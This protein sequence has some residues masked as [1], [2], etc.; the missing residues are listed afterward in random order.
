MMEWVQIISY[1]LTNELHLFLGLFLVAR[2]TNFQPERN[3]L[4]F[5]AAGGVLAAILQIML[6][7]SVG[8]LAVELLVIAAVA[9]YYQRKKIKNILFLIFFYDVGVG[10]WDFLLQAGLGILFRS[11]K[12]INPSVP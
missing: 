7:P 9:W 11:E 1:L 4:M 2:V 5:S 10:L 3:A 8:V 12:F 6:F